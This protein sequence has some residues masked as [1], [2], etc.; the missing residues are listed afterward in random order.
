[1]L[2]VRPSVSFS[3][4]F[5]KTKRRFFQVYYR[6]T[7]QGTLSAANMAAKL[8]N[9]MTLI[10]GTMGISTAH[11]VPW[12]WTVSSFA[13][14]CTAATCRYSLKVAA[15]SGP[16]G[17]PSFD[18]SLCSGTSIQAGYRPCGI[19]NI[20]VPGTV[21]TREINLG[22]KVGATVVVQYTFVA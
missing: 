13:S 19:A 2:R 11:D 16:A 5:S 12:T 21:Q 18:A 20:G 3:L 15:P 9:F 17:E 4:V 10:V 1:M 7:H 22:I 14:V 6:S 8:V